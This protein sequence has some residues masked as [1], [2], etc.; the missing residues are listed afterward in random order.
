MVQFVST[1]A[2]IDNVDVQGQCISRKPK[3]MGDGSLSNSRMWDKCDGSQNQRSQPHDYSS[4]LIIYPAVVR[5]AFDVRS[6]D[7]IIC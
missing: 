6:C 7:Y 3:Q 1:L 2:E 5:Q 4:C